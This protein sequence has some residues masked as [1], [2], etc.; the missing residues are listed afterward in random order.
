MNKAEQPFSIQIEQWLKSSGPKTFKGLQEVF[1]EKSLAIFILLL[2]FLPALPIPTGGLT[3]V[4]EVIAMIIA[5]EMILGIHEFW[6]PKMLLKKQLSDN[7]LKKSIPFIVRRVQW[8]ERFSRPRMVGVINNSM[9][10]RFAGLM[11]LAFSIGAFSAPWFSG[12]DTLPALGAV[13]IAL[14]LI[15]DDM[16]IFVLGVIVGLF[17]IGLEL[18]LGATVIQIVKHL[19]I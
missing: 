13:M 11:I 19:I 18:A 16:V 15:L 5:I 4:F 14:S 6:L 2:M 17:G 10:L 1:G 3:H 8:F 12:L 7:M 9:F